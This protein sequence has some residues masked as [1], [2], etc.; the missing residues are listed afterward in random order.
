M[1]KNV[2][3]NSVEHRDLKV[4]TTRGAHYGDAV[5]FTVTFPKEFRTV[6]AHYPI[7]FTKIATAISF[8]L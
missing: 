6:Q 4:I 1:S 8:S 2:L 3:L 5:W 7:F